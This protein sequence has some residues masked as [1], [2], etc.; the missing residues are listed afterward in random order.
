VKIGF[1]FDDTLDNMDGVQQYITTLG[2]WYVSQGHQVHYLVGQT[3]T[4]E[5]AGGTVHSLS[6]NIHVRFNGNRLSVPLPTSRRR[7]KQLLHELQL[8]VLHVQM[9]FSPFMG[10]KVITAAPARTA[11][12]ATFH[13]APYSRFVAVANRALAQLIR[14]SVRR[15]D[16]IV[17]VSS[18]AA[19]FAKRCYGLTTDLLP[20]VVNEARFKAAARP[21]PEQPKTIVFLGRLVPRKGC[22]ILLEAVALLQENGQLEGWQ[23]KIGGRGPLQ[24]SL[25][26]YVAEHNLQAVSFEGFVTEAAKPDFLA[27]S[28]LAVFPSSGGESFGIVLIEAMA[29]QLPVVLAGDNPGYHSVMADRPDQLFAPHDA[30]E[31]ADK[32]H[33]FMTDPL[34]VEDA[35]AWQQLAVGQYDVAAVGGKLIDLYYQILQS[36]RS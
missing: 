20:N 9:P 25:E 26:K 19:D 32:L 24:G 12:I 21:L 15:A 16:K 5:V 36:R 13:I 29:S 28:R 35:Q 7:I 8:D 1:V 2:S 18:A 31:L 10:A 34:A 11:V 27:A 3:A 23:V 4:A 22:Q 14:R 6:R 30:V 33:I 17:S